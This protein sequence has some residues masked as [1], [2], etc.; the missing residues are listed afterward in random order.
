M[1]G[2]MKK[3]I[4]W[5]VLVCSCLT[6]WAEKPVVKS[7]TEPQ[8][9]QV[10]VSVTY[11]FDRLE[12]FVGLEKDFFDLNKNAC[13]LTVAPSYKSTDTDMEYAYY[14]FTFTA[15]YNAMSLVAAAGMEKANK[16]KFNEATS[17]S[18]AVATPNAGAVSITNWCNS[19]V[20]G[21]VSNL[22]PWWR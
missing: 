20:I 21:V 4:V 7:V 2:S 6:G 8:A 11:D 9:F 3:S 16:S 12:K 13:T 15:V 10:T 1:K 14:A 19:Y 18:L 17:I 22:N 5:L